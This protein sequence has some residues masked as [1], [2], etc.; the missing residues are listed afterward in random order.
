MRKCAYGSSIA[1]FVLAV[2]CAPAESDDAAEP[3]LVDLRG[4]E[5]VVYGDASFSLPTLVLEPVE[6][7][8]AAFYLW[9]DDSVGMLVSGRN[10]QEYLSDLGLE[11]ATP[12]TVYWA[13]SDEGAGVPSLLVAAHGE[14][15]A[16]ND[17]TLDWPSIA[18]H[19]RQG[20]A[21]ERSI[22][23]FRDVDPC[24]NTEFD[25]NHCPPPGTWDSSWC[26]FDHDAGLSWTSG[27][28]RKWKAGFCLDVGNVN[29]YLYYQV[30][31][32]DCSYFATANYIWGNP[33]D[34][35][36]WA[37]PTYQTWTWIAAGSTAS[38]KWKHHAYNAA[39]SDNFDWSRNQSNGTI[40]D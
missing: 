20:W 25:S 40:C 33:F 36:A 15:V 22:I 14:A 9:E 19:D 37:A 38:R 17:E 11:H 10:S 13:L 1:S 27:A 32:A 28:T 29:D 23:D 16:S 18:A 24:D 39:G 3:R 30:Q 12:A 35:D 5:T 2:G 21:L 26:A 7:V 31:A 8:R 4:V 34:G 6:G